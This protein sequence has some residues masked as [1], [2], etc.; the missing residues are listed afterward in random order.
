MSKKANTMLEIKRS[1]P[2]ALE[3]HQGGRN[4]KTST[5]ADDTGPPS[6]GLGENGR[7]TTARP[8]ATCTARS[9]ATSKA[10]PSSG[11]Q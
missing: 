3:G 1:A 8:S 7:Y 10:A 5:P 2:S 11:R 6:E 9:P 4:V